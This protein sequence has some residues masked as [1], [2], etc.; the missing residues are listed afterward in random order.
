VTAPADQA[1]EKLVTL[2]EVAAQLGLPVETLRYWR[3]AGRFP[4]GIKVDPRPQ[5]RVYFRWSDINT[6]LNGHREPTEPPQHR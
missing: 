4:R 3:T 6:W 2:G 5:G 1:P